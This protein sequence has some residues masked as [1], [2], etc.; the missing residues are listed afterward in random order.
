MAHIIPES[1]RQGLTQLRHDL[2]E[3][4]DRWWHRHGHM[5]T[6]DAAV[7]VR[8]ATAEL[9][10]NN[11]WPLNVSSFFSSQLPSIDVEETDDDVVVMAELPGLEKEDF[12]VDVSS[13][14]WLR[15]RG[16]KKQSSQQKTQSA[17]YAEC[18]YGAF[19]RIVPLPC[20]ID[21]D[22]A[23]AIYKQGALTI[24]LPKTDR[25]KSRRIKIQAHG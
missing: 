15:I 3:T 1:W 10:D 8:R 20:E 5:A 17:T 16:E 25:S 22:Q 4:I 2:H 14:R 13:D 12:T 19:A 18:R 6:G 7:P 9:I 23:K 24:T 11:S 21:A